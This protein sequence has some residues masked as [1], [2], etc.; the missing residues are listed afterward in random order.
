M[1]NVWRISPVHLASARKDSPENIA[2][3]EYVKSVMTAGSLSSQFITP[4]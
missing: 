2:K 4:G 3:V 1:A